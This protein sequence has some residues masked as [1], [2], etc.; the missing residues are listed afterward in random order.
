MLN[1]KY[2]QFG[3]TTARVAGCLGAG[4]KIDILGMF[5]TPTAEERL[6]YKQEVSMYRLL[7]RPDPLLNTDVTSGA[8]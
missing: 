2:V 7:P 3:S 5:Q 8:M 6:G 1:N 4:G